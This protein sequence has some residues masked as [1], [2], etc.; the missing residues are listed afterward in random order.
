MQRGIASYQAGRFAEAERSFR[1]VLETIPDDANA[2][3]LLGVVLYGTGRHEDAVAHI[4][5]SIGHAPENAS[6][7]NNLGNV[8]NDLGRTHEAFDCFEHAIAID[9]DLAEAHNNLGN[10]LKDRARARD[11]VHHFER[12]LALNP[13]FAEAHNN[14]GNLLAGAGR[15]D[16]ALACFQKALAIR[17]DF[18]DAHFN[19]ANVL[20]ELNRLDAAAA[21]YG[22]ALKARPDFADARNALGNLFKDQGRLDEAAACYEKA[23]VFRPDDVDARNNLGNLF[24][25]QGRPDEAVASFRRAFAVD[26]AGSGYARHMVAAITGETT[27]AAPADYIRKLFD[28]YAPRFDAHLVGELGYAVPEL[29]RRAVDRLHE[30]K[31]VFGRA[32]DLGCGTGL[33]GEAFREK[34]KELHEVDLS[35]KMLDRARRK[36]VYDAV[37]L[38]DVHDCLRRY[39]AEAMTFNLVLAAELFI[40]IGNLEPIFARVAEVLAPGG[41]FAFS[42]EGTDDGAFKLLRTGRYAHG[43]D[44]VRALASRH[45][46]SVDTSD[47]IEIRQ[48]AHEFAAGRLYVLSV[49]A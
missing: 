41:L 19:R 10:L 20:V 29:M 7:H 17:P 3:H 12:A 32:L 45:G 31:G 11:A 49:S 1:T 43:A 46:L 44:Y 37:H 26:P 40:Y 5:K 47:E 14:L 35:A 38:E 33:V 42:V 13:E 39:A 25:L 30:D 6:F 2:H 28:G 27:E 8:L 21:G 16:D 22:E 48:Q 18:A 23:L 34:V 36:G 15:L 4:R 9:P 24:M